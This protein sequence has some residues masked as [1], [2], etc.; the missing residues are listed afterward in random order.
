MVSATVPKAGREPVKKPPYAAGADGQFAPVVDQVMRWVESYEFVADAIPFY[1]V[2][3]GADHFAA[4]LGADL[5]FHESDPGSWVVPFLADV[6][7]ADLRFRPEGKWWQRTVEFVHALRARCDGA[8][9]LA[10]PTLN[11]NLDA[12]AAIHG[13]E[14]LLMSLVDNPDA[15][16]RALTQITK[17][18][19]DVLKAFSDLFDFAGY[20]SINRHGMYARGSINVPQCDFSCM[21]STDMFREFAV[22]YLREEMRRYDGVEYHLDGPDALK[23]L[24]ALCEIEDLDVIQWVPGSGNAEKTDWAWLEQRID[25]LGKGQLRYTDL[26]Q[27]RKIHQDSLSRRQY[28]FTWASSR[29]E[30]EDCVAT[31]EK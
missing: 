6:A 12:L 10:A 18:H 25:S 1:T 22:P 28:V 2:D 7:D 19:G 20:G 15:V 9:L 31:L 16:H 11:A 4:L 29:A 17:A 14:N 13:T 5:R 26:N 8:L 27:L 21:I 24:E 30:I 23:H 3:F